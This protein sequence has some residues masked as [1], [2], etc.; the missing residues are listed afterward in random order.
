MIAMVPT[1]RERSIHLLLSPALLL[2][3]A[4]VFGVALLSSVAAIAAA[5]RSPLLAALRSE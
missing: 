5:A 3:L 4:G 2:M 1:A